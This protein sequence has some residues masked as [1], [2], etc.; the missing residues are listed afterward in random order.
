MS[1]LKMYW[2]P[3]TPITEYELPEG[4]SISNF[5][6]IEDVD[7]WAKIC[8]NGLVDYADGARCFMQDVYGR[9]DVKPYED[10]FFLDYKGEHIGTVTAYLDTKGNFGDVHMVAIRTDFR[11]KGLGKYLNM[12][13]LKHFE[14]NGMRFAALTT[15]EFRTAAVKSYLNAGFKPVEYSIGMEERWGKVLETYDIDSVDMYYEDGTF[16]KKIV[17]KAEQQIIKFGVF[18]A[19]RGSTMINY[20]KWNDNAKLVAI[21]DAREESLKRHREEPDFKDVHFYNDFDEFLK[22]DMDCVVLANFANEHTPY[23]IRCLNAGKNVLSEVLPVQNMKEAVELIETVEKTGL[24]YAYAENYCFMPAPKKMRE[25]YK[26]GLLGSFEYGEGEYVHNCEAP[27]P[28]LT[29]AGNPLHWRNT[30]SAFYYCTHSIGPLVH[31]TGQRPV[32]VSGFE[33]PFNNRMWRMGAKAGAMA[34]EMITLESGAVLKSVHG[35][36]PSRNSIWYSIY[37]SKGRLESEREDAPDSK[38]VHTLYS[39]LD[40]FEGGNHLHNNK[41]VNTDDDMSEFAEH[42]GH[43]G[44]D[45]YIMYNMVQRL[46]GNKNADTVDVYE[47]LDMFLPGFFAHLSALAGGAPMDIPNLRDKNEREKWRND[48]RCT[49]PKNPDYEVIPSYSKGN[50]EIPDENYQ[51]LKEWYDAGK[52]DHLDIPEQKG[53]PQG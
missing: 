15:D 2:F 12:I 17:K 50:P 30:M 8:D 31:I 28:G 11:G 10:I 39:N 14:G 36:G 41:V 35:V 40:E 1:Q 45:F 24:V 25:M 33:I 47:A 20:C 48:T 34:V 23:A 51:I 37:G 6:S 5:K 13:A 49:D 16:Y 29:H 19:G 7:D 18:G 27:W 42:T 44:S 22:E 4:Y 32:K 26:K 53:G 9:R 52:G 43:G 3:G 46:R 38:G 21:C